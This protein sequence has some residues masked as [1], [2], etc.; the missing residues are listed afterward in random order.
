MK[1][2]DACG[3]YPI[4]GG[5]LLACARPATPPTS[6]F[7]ALDLIHTLSGTERG[8]GPRP[9]VTPRDRE[10]PHNLAR[11]C[12]WWWGRWF[13]HGFARGT[14]FKSSR[15]ETIQVEVERGS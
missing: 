12:I 7:F 4:G 6:L 11:R 2:L 13:P 1:E 14:Q 15:N 9:T 5:H 10:T 3:L 8:T